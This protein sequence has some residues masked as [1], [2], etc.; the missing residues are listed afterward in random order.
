MEN[1]DRLAEQLKSLM[2]LASKADPIAAAFAAGRRSGKRQAR[3]WQATS[4]LTILFC[5]IIWISRPV[6]PNSES[7]PQFMLTAESTIPLS[8]ESELKMERA[9]LDRGI[10]ALPPVQSMTILRTNTNNSL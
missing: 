3:I 6:V 7:Q 9:V 10:D 8:D 5:G 2:P 4:A 1:Q